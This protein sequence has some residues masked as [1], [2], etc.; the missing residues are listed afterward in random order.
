MYTSIKIFSQV[1]S[2][3]LASLSSLQSIHKLDDYNTLGNLNILSTSY[4]LN[5]FLSYLFLLHIYIYV[6]FHTYSYVFS[7]NKRKTKPKKQQYL[8]KIKNKKTHNTD[9]W[10]LILLPYKIRSLWWYKLLPVFP[11]FLKFVPILI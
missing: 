11:I 6:N 4:S 1:V 10:R 2:T 7:F 3:Q 5:K 8:N 9:E